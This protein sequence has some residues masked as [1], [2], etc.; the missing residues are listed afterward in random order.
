MAPVTEIETE[1]EAV[2]ETPVS[3][4]LVFLSE[5]FRKLKISLLFS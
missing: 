3:C 2:M 1:S 5:P 4:E